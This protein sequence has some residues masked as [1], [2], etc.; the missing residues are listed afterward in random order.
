[1]ASISGLETANFQGVGVRPGLSGPKVSAWKRSWALLGVAVV[2]CWAVV[3]C[4]PSKQ[5]AI[6]KSE[7]MLKG[8]RT[9]ASP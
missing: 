2:K 3:V 5:A 9:R 4:Q 6:A 7:P 1:M 8:S